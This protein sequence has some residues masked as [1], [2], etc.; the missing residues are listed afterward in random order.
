LKRKTLPT[1]G[2]T[3]ERA[4][5]ALHLL[6]AE[7]KIAATDVTA[8]L[9]RRQTLIRDLRER[10]VALEQGVVSAIER[11]GRQIAQKVAR[12]KRNMTPARR[13]AL[14]LHGRYLGHVRPLSKAAK[15]KVK[16]V[17]GKSGVRAAIAAA[18]RLAKK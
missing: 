7:G 11:T 12:K 17:R 18:K 15:A 16:A 9:K 5:H 3:N 13:A 10:L 6:V 8:A 4:L 14:Q 2:I 1:L